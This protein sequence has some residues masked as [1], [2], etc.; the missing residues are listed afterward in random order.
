MNDHIRRRAFPWIARATWLVVALTSSCRSDEPE[1]PRLRIGLLAVLEGDIYETSGRPSLEGAL[2][3]AQTTNEA[4]GIVID[5]TAHDVEIVVRDYEGR[6]D[7][8][9]S[10]ARVLINQERVSA[11]VGPQVS[12]HAIP[13]SVVAE[14][15]SVPMVSPMSSNPATTAGK[16]FVFRIAFLDEVQSQLMARLAII[17]LGA[18][19]AAILYDRSTAYG[20]TLAKTFDE[21]F[22]SAGGTVVARESFARDQELDFSE[23][24]RAIKAAEPDVL[25]LPNDVER[26][27]VQLRQAHGMG[28]TADLLGADTWDLEIL[29]NLPE[30]QGAFVPHQWHPEVGTDGSQEF[31]ALYRRKYD[32]TPKVTAAMTFDAVKL[33]IAAAAAE[34]STRPESIRSGLAATEGFVGV[35]GP[36]SYVNSHD[37]PRA[38]VISRI[39]DG[40]NELFELVEPPRGSSGSEEERSRPPSGT[41]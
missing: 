17:E 9:S 16:E 25:Y 26:L 37:P 20:R 10:S 5:G 41:Q 1:S 19:R 32:A 38:V 28:I 12:H 18:K 15:A 13:A 33:I 2:L 4:G 21:A 36:V 29:K 7:A 40:E 27:V 14:D 34:G 24:L 6:P 30:S 22:E 23:Q 11:I 35:T 39:V 3:A 8:A 31:V